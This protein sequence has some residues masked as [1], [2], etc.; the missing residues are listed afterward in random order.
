M[1]TAEFLLSGGQSMTWLIGNRLI[2]VTTSGCSQK[3]LKYGLCD[4]C[5]TLCKLENPK[6][7]ENE[8][9]SRSTR[10]GSSE[11]DKEE[12]GSNRASRQNSDEKS[13]TNT[14]ASSPIEENK[15]LSD[16]L[17]QLPSQLQQIDK[18]GCACWCQGWAEIY[19]R[20]PTGQCIFFKLLQN[21]DVP[22]HFVSTEKSPD[23]MC[24]TVAILDSNVT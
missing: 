6:T 14:S 3:P 2:T 18:L 19:V 9:Q 12:S 8:K 4:K 7:P 22:L 17:E 13:N 23:A 16:K 20:R 5:W 1:P 24:R 15:R 11:K 21:H 10:S